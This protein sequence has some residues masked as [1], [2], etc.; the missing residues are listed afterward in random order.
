MSFVCFF[1]FLRQPR[2]PLTTSDNI[3]FRA[4]RGT[5][6][7]SIV[8]PV[9]VSSLFVPSPARNYSCKFV[10]FVVKNVPSL[11]R[12][13]LVVPCCLLLFLLS[14]LL[15]SFRAPRG[16][17]LLSHVVY[18]CSCCR[19]FSFRSEPREEP[20]CCPLLSFVVL[21][22][23]YFLFVPSPARNPIVVHCCLLLFLLSFL[24]FSFRAPRGTPCCSSCRFISSCRYS[25]IALNPLPR[26]SL[27]SITL[28]KAL[29]SMS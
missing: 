6:L 24:L 10:S 15:L 16:T 3:F 18:C 5:L 4:L 9:V 7:L 20:S 27:L 22:V 11:A 21:V 1:S 2:Q 29:G 13:P 14:F 8:V 26:I 28:M 23:V 19:F 25:F 17:L 12:S